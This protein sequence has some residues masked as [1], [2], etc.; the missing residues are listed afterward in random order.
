MYSLIYKS[1]NHPRFNCGHY[2]MKVF[3]LCHMIRFT[4]VLLVSQEIL[5]NY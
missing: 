4:E 1:I 3:P 2:V 5:E